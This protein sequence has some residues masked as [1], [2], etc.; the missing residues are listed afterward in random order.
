MDVPVLDY[1]QPAPSRIPPLLVRVFSAL[2][3]LPFLAGFVLMEIGGPG[4][5]RR[6]WEGVWSVP[7]YGWDYRAAWPMYVLALGAAGAAMCAAIRPR[8]AAQSRLCTVGLLIGMG[9][10]LYYFGTVGAIL[11]DT[12]GAYGVSLVSLLAGVVICRWL[13]GPTHAEMRPWHRLTLGTALLGLAYAIPML[14]VVLIDV[15]KLLPAIGWLGLLMLVTPILPLVGFC[16][17]RQHLRQYPADSLRPSALATASIGS[18]ILANWLLAWFLHEPIQATASS[19]CYVATAASR[20]HRWLVGAYAII[21]EGRPLWINDQ[22]RTLVL[23]ELVMRQL[24]PAAAQW[25]RGHY[26]RFGPPCAARID[27]PWKADL[28][29]VLIKPIEW[30]AFSYLC[31]V[32]LSGLHRRTG[33][34]L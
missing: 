28:A 25:L 14:G 32:M 19:L 30:A 12:A 33:R 34:G 26:D 31:L 20:G 17:L 10:C 15:R 29:Y 16:M 4:Q 21:C 3:L 24:H 5:L 8:F 6:P 9:I 22:L 1:R 13:Q 18:G 23:F 27:R 2:T 7:L 11:M